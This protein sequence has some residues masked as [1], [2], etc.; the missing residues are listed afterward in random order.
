VVNRI[1]RHL[2][3]VVLLCAG[4]PASSAQELAKL[5]WDHKLV[6]YTPAEAPAYDAWIITPPAGGSPDPRALAAVLDDIF[7]RENT[8]ISHIYLA[9]LIRGPELQADV[10]A[11]VLAHPEFQKQPPPKGFSRW[12]F[13]DNA[14][15]RALIEQGMLHARFVADCN[16]ALA[17]HGRAVQW[18]SMEKLFFTKKDGQWGWDAITWLMLEPRPKSVP[19]RSGKK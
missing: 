3:L 16:S 9:A 14:K 10:I 4:G 19:D 11:Y 2:A 17:K 8:V 7:Q 12:A 5:L 6:H 18:V 1:V 13:R 15:M